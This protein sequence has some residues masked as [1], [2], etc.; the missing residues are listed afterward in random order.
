MYKSESI[1]SVLHNRLIRR[2]RVLL[3]AEP[4]IN[5]RFLYSNPESEMFHYDPVVLAMFLLDYIIESMGLGNDADSNAVINSLA[6]IMRQMDAAADFEPDARR[7][8][9]FIR[10]ILNRLREKCEVKYDDFDGTQVIKRKLEFKVISDRWISDEKAVLELSPE[11]I[12]IFLNALDLEVEDAQV[13]LEAV[14]QYQLER[15]HFSKATASAKDAKFRSIQ[16]ENKIERLLIETRRDISRV[17]W[18]EMMPNL[19]RE[20]LTHIKL[21]LQIEKHIADVARER[22]DELELGSEEASQVA[23][24]AELMDDCSAR[25]TRLHGKLIDARE[26]FFSEQ[27]R[28]SFVFRP[29]ARFLPNLFTDV[30]EPLFLLDKTESLAILESSNDSFEGAVSSLFGARKPEIFS[31]KS[32]I[33]WNLRPRRPEIHTTINDEDENWQDSMP[34][35]VRYPPET[36][37]KAQSYIKNLPIRL[38]VMLEKA[39]IN[40]ENQAVLEHICLDALQTF[41]NDPRKGLQA[42]PVGILF[43]QNGFSGDDLE[44]NNDKEFHT[45]M[46]ENEKENA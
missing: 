1:D 8:E 32:L 13:A 42:E 22:L 38:S 31:L 17:D 6:P 35:V 41:E 44:L 14:I 18:R 4:I 24:I 43:T 3:H 21:R 40:G 19:I 15:G 12:N 23:L 45:E 2:L 30:L 11:A 28:Q 7:H 25:H 37:Q 34:D 39:A 27:S 36:S 16:F 29:E 46:T 33:S 20:A 5:L 9:Q 10:K 26:T